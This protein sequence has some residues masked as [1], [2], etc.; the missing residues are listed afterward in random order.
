MEKTKVAG[1]VW[2]FLVVG[3]LITVGLLLLFTRTSTLFRPYYEI[4][5]RTRF[6]GELKP[7]ASVLM[8]GIQVG[9]V[10]TIKLEPDLSQAIVKIR[11]LD[12]Y[13]I[14]NNSRFTI[15]QRG[16]LGEQ[17]VAV[18]PARGG[19]EFLKDGDWVDSAEIID[20]LQAARLTRG[21][22]NRIEETASKLKHTVTRSE[23]LINTNTLQKGEKIGNNFSDTINGVSTVFNKITNL[24]ELNRPYVGNVSSNI[25][26]IEME[27]RNLVAKYSIFTNRIINLTETNKSCWETIKSNVESAKLISKN[28]SLEK[29]DSEKTTDISALNLKITRLLKGLE[30][31][32][33]FSSNLNSRGIVGAIK[34]KE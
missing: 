14:K 6:I 4:T 24:V 18:Y 28:I 31:A 25:E 7:G 23:L 12:T 15:E 3:V 11:I 21:M 27:W 22:V 5:M 34:D 8:S 30:K 2:L 9:N 17:Y 16:F 13:K 20:F 19:E 10:K 26:N 1:K 29:S 33:K 32:N